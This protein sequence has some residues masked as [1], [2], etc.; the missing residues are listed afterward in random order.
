MAEEVSIPKL[1]SHFELLSF[2]WV[3]EVEE[4]RIDFVPGFNLLSGG[5]QIDLKI[6]LRLLLYAIG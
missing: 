4:D 5:T 1:D 3:K 6:I 2:S